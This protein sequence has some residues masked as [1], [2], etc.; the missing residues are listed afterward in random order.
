MQGSM[1][2]TGFNFGISM[3]LAGLH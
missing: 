1:E 2:R 3:L